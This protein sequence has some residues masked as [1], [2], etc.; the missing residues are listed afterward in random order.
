MPSEP[1]LPGPYYIEQRAG[2]VA[3]DS[4]YQIPAG[5]MIDLLDA[6]PLSDPME[7]WPIDLS[8][9][10]TAGNQTSLVRYVELTHRLGVGDEVRGWTDHDLTEA[11]MIAKAGGGGLTFST[12]PYGAIP[13][14]GDPKIWHDVAKELDYTKRQLERCRRL[15]LNIQ[16]ILFDAERYKVAS[17]L[18]TTR[19]YQ[20]YCITKVYYPAVRII[21]YRNGEW[22]PVLDV[23]NEGI[24]TVQHYQ[25]WSYKWTE[26]R[27][28]RAQ[29]AFPDTKQ[30]AAWTSFGCGY[31]PDNKWNWDL[32]LSEHLYT[33]IGA[34]HA[35][36]KI[37]AIAYPSVLRPITMPGSLDAFLA[38]VRGRNGQ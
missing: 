37:T 23:L 35:A 20:M 19:F 17:E 24:R 15:N 12:M 32:G 6:K 16:C 13:G 14:P 18:V 21:W 5:S 8:V 38:Y 10:R 3:A 27:M 9:L 31:G 29:D 1:Y 25:I 28:K 34:Y 30:W 36:N 11:D 26:A 22:A 2:G 7:T 33:R 4:S